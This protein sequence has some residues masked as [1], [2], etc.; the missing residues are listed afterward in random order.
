MLS[1]TS[2]NYCVYVGQVLDYMS[3]D[4]GRLASVWNVHLF[5]SMPAMIMFCLYFLYLQIGLSFLAG[6]G[7]CV[8]VIGINQVLTVLIAKVLKKYMHFKDER[9]KL[10]SEILTGARVIKLYAWEKLF[11]SKVLVIKPSFIAFYQPLIQIQL[12]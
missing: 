10:M 5:W 3:T 2:V 12:F 9:I 6:L 7:F 4:A 8:G 11:K 1:E